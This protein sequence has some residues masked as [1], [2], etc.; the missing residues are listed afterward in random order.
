MAPADGLSGSFDYFSAARVEVIETGT[1]G[2]LEVRDQHTDDKGFGLAN[3]LSWLVDGWDYDTHYTVR[4]SNIRMPDGSSRD[5]EYPVVVDRYNLFNVDHPLEDTDSRA[6]DTLK[7]K[8]DPSGDKDSYST[9]HYSGS[10]RVS[11]SSQFSNMAFFVLIYDQDKRL[12]TSSDEPFSVELPPG[13]DTVIISNCDE[14]GLCYQGE[15]N[16]SVTFSAR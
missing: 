9:P 12:I 1:G 3:F 10:F 8:L 2:S 15:K 16:Y 5:L 11:G 6:G 4:I 14:N 13:A 7:G